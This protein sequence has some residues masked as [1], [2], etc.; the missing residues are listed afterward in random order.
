[1]WVCLLKVKEYDMC[2]TSNREIEGLGCTRQRRRNDKE[3]RLKVQKR[4]N[5][6]ELKST[7]EQHSERK[8]R[9]S[10]EE[11]VNGGCGGSSLH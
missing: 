9:A 11:E 10:F 1:M 4:Q 7:S 2:K 6:N 3:R 8:S 5:E